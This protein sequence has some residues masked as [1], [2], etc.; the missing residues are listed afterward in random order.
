MTLGP[1]VD[2]GVAT[3]VRDISGE[4]CSKGG[5]GKAFKKLDVVGTLK[6]INLLTFAQSDFTV[7]N[8]SINQFLKLVFK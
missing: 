7:N 2:G 4:S 3:L 5:G 8:K 1:R 6:H